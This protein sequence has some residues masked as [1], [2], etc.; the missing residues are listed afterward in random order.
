MTMEEN[1]SKKIQKQVAETEKKIDD[2]ATDVQKEF[3]ST[4]E[5]IS[6][7]V[8]SCAAA[9]VELGLKL[10]KNLNAAR[11]LPDAMAAYEDWL[12]KEMNARS[13]DARRFMTNTQRLMNAGTRVF[14]NAW[15]GERMSP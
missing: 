9:E 8:M 13:E 3:L 7:E 4:L 12:S 1:V 11:S 15:S 2:A 14:S 10:S 5:E 6:R